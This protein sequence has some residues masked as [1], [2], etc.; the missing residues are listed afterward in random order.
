MTMGEDEERVET[1]V[2][3]LTHDGEPCALF[4]TETVEMKDGTYKK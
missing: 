2:T 4:L 3:D 1:P